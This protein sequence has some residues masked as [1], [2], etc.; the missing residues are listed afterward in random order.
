MTPELERRLRDA[1]IACRVEIR[2]RLAILIPDVPS[3][4]VSRDER[5]RALRIAREE[6]FSHAAIEIDPDVAAVSRD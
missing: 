3:E 6:G 4:S 1:G 5:L 2:D